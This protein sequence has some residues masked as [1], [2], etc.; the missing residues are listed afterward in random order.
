MT[1]MD[2]IYEPI[3]ARLREAGVTRAIVA[4]NLFGTPSVEELTDDIADF[5]NYVERAEGLLEELEAMGIGTSGVVDIDECA[6]SKLWNGR[7]DG[8]K[9]S[10]I[11]KERLFPQ[12]LQGLGSLLAIVGS[13]EF[14]GLDVTKVG[15]ELELDENLPPVNLVFLDYYW[16]AVTNTDSPKRA[17]VI[18][19]EVYNR[20]AAAQERPFTILMSSR[21]EVKNLAEEFRT[22]SDLLGGL[23]DF[24]LR[25]EL[26]DQSVLAFKLATWAA[27]MATRHKIQDFV[28]TLGNTIHPKSDTF[29][30]KVR[31]LTIE[32]Y[33]YV[34]A[35]S[36]RPDGHPLGDY[37]LWL[38]GSLL[39]NSVLESN[40]E[41]VE[42]RKILDEL[43]FASF[44]P[45][46]KPP[47]PYLAEI[48]G[49]AVAEPARGEIETHPLDG[50]TE[51]EK[52]LPILRFGDLLIRDAI[53][54]IYMVATPDCDLAFAPDSKRK[55]D[56]GLSVIL[57]PGRLQSLSDNETHPHFRTDLFH[58]QGGQYRIYWEPQKVI[59]KPVGQIRK[60]CKD[61]KYSRF[62]RIRT[63]YAIRIQQEFT[64]GLGRVGT[65]VSPPI[66]E[67]V[68]MQ[69][70]CEGPGATWQILGESEVSGATVMHTRDDRTFVL[71]SIEYVQKLQKQIA[72]VIEIYKENREGFKTDNPTRSQRYTNKIKRVGEFQIDPERL[73]S[74]VEGRWP[75]PDSEESIGLIPDTIGLHRNG[76]F[77]NGCPAGHLICLNIL[78]KEGHA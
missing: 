35:I 22:D 71:I 58:Y 49:L 21:P 48:Y 24:V 42:K 50:A 75:I 77:S 65:P 39:V 73:L 33:A 16:G 27:G 32:D 12:V 29:I 36:L 8:S 2:E 47:S 76:D 64:S 51:P 18:A 14:L 61:C 10:K 66:F 53:S 25:E 63:P 28:E 60:W 37:M 17:G 40:E 20:H 78:Y 70:Y 15:S 41:L 54:T 5:W 45:S 74:L 38:F 52:R 67:Q 59:S 34:Q 1:S 30:Q 23:F 19:R 13:L 4:D 69:L 11:A 9:I 43:S 55:L 57:V 68:D 3:K 7:D 62:A 31:S 26:H 72:A 56:P 46:Q 6:I 44:L